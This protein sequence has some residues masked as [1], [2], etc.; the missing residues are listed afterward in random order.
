MSRTAIDMLGQHIGK[1]T[2][3]SKS[4][5]QTKNKNTYW[6]CQCECGTLQEICGTDLRRRKT[7]QCK[8]CSGLIAKQ[9]LLSVNNIKHTKQNNDEIGKVYGQLT[10]LEKIEQT[11]GGSI[12]RCKCSCGNEINVRINNLHSGKTQSCGCIKSRGENIIN[13]ILQENNIIYKREYTFDDLLG[14]NHGKLRFDFAIFNKENQLIKLIEFQGRQHFEE[15]KVWNNDNKIHDEYKRK[16]CKEHNIELLE[17]P[18]YDINKIDLN[19]L[20]L[21]TLM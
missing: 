11:L 14:V 16:Y 6:L 2:V 7:L 4:N 20:G 5:K 17:I 19:Y 8:H 13:R 12:W 1:W 3:I 10:V 15:T 9:N 21:I 18:Y